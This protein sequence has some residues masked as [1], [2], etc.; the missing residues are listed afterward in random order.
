MQYLG[1]VL[2]DTHGEGQPLAAAEYNALVRVIDAQLMG[3]ALKGI[4]AGIISGFEVT[5]GPGLSAAIAAGSAVLPFGEGL[6]YVELASPLALSGLTDNRGAVYFWIEALSLEATDFDSRQDAECRIV[7][8]TANTPPANSLPL[9]LGSTSGG[10]FVLGTDLRTYCPARQG[11]A[12]A[13]AVAALQTAVGAD[14]ANARSLDTRVSELEATGGSV[15]GGYRIFKDMPYDIGDDTT[16]PQMMDAKDKASMDAHVA[17]MHGAAGGGS[18][19]ISVDDQTTDLVSV[20]GALAVMQDI[21]TDNPAAGALLIDTAILVPGKWGDG[22][23]YV[24]HNGATQASPDYID[25]VHSTWLTG[26]H[27]PE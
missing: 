13:A 11:A 4:G 8:N 17:A 1:D 7:W 2:S 3:G 20:N 9:H 24:D 5:A 18:D 25:R 19:T 21:M 10:A 23:P 15:T 16:P 6:V 27:V 12:L 22:S 26:L 14:Y